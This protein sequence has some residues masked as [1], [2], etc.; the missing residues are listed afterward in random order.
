V[1]TWARVF[2]VVALPMGIAAGVA[3]AFGSEGSSTPEVANQAIANTPAVQEVPA[4]SPRAA[5]SVG[6]SVVSITVL[7]TVRQSASRNLM[8]E[9][10]RS[11]PRQRQRQ[12]RGLGSGFAIDEDGYVLTNEH[13]VS[14]ADSIVVTDGQGRHLRAELVGADALTDI[15]VLK[16][17]A[18]RV[19]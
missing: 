7:R 3:I 15:A 1:K 18:G 4:L 8:E 9:F 6:P 5:Q 12:V 2:L 19:L 10:F 13:V 17:E 14:G 16:V 11:I